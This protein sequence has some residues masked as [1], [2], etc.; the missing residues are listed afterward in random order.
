MKTYCTIDT[1]AQVSIMNKQFAVEHN[2]EFEQIEG[3]PIFV[4]GTQ[5]QRQRTTQ[6]LSLDYDG[7]DKTMFHKFDIVGNKYMKSSNQILASADLMLKLN[8]RLINVAHKYKDTSK[9]VDD[10]IDD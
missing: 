8:M 10:S 4:D 3:T 5:I 1:G 9:S 6:P 7:V 2:I